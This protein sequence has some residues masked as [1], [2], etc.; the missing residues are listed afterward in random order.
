MEKQRIRLKNS[1]GLKDL[2]TDEELLELIESILS[3]YG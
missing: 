3:K 1:G 2:S